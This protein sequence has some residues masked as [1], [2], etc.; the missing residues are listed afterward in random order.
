LTSSLEELT[1]NDQAAHETVAPTPTVSDNDG[2][3]PPVVYFSRVSVFDR[4]PWQPWQPGPPI[5]FVEEVD[6]PD[7]LGSSP[8]MVTDKSDVSEVESARTALLH[9]ADQVADPESN[10]GAT[11]GDSSIQSL[12]KMEFDSSPRFSSVAAEISAP[13]DQGKFSYARF[14]NGINRSN[15][16][17]PLLYSNAV[18]EDD[19]SYINQNLNESTQEK[20]DWSSD[21]YDDDLGPI[22]F[23]LLSKKGR[24][25]ASEAKNKVVTT[26]SNDK[27]F[28][29]TAPEHSLISKAAITEVEEERREFVQG[30]SSKP[31]EKGKGRWVPSPTNADEYFEAKRTERNILKEKHRNKRLKEKERLKQDRYRRS[32]KWVSPKISA[33]QH[34]EQMRSERQELKDII[35]KR[36]ALEEREKMLREEKKNTHRTSAP[37]RAESLRPAGGYYTQ[38]AEKSDPSSPSSSDSDTDSSVSSEI[39]NR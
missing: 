23:Y 30:T 10:F 5:P 24:K 19:S 6:I 36:R 3:D 34:R 16:S 20:F 29:M 39:P 2:L 33:E 32:T 18:S 38:Q 11:M 1:I 26:Y 27:V 17:S 35:R 13:I 22:P 4:E 21:E 31:V 8:S 37:L 15:I 12:Y 14:E 7:C 25:A 28:F 9:Q